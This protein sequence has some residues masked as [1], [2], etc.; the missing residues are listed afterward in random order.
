MQKAGGW[1]WGADDTEKTEKHQLWN[2]EAQGPLSAPLVVGSH[3][4][5]WVGHF[6]LSLPFISDTIFQEALD[7][8]FKQF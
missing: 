5:L 3:V 8:Y 2:T 1:G 7:K 4:R 6:L